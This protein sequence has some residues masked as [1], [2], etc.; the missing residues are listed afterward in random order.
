ML[1]FQDQGEN[2]QN[3]AVS[4][5][6]TTK[7]TRHSGAKRRNDVSFAVFLLFFL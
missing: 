6:S 1:K 2:V 7:M 3:N 5:N 4:I